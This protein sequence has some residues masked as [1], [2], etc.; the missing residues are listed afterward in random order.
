[1][2]KPKKFGAFAGVFTPS[3]LTI[4]GVIMYMRLGWVVGNAGLITALIIIV[5]SHV[6]SL[7]TGLSISSVATDKKI[8]TGGIYYILSRSLGFPM[9]GAIG[10]ALFIGTALGISLYLVGFAES[11][12]AV[13]E[14]SKFLN[15]NP[16]DTNSLR[17]IASASLL[18][19]VTIAFISTSLAIKSQYFILGAIALSL[20]SI[21]IGFF[22]KTEFA[23][24][25]ISFSPP[26][27]GVSMQVVFGVFFPAVTGFTAGVAM[28]GDLKDPKKG[29]PVG[30]MSAIIVGFVIYILL[31]VSFAV[32]VNSDLLMN[33][34]N[35]LLKIAYFSP[36]VLA[37]IW[38]AT[39]SS[40][41][42]G[43]L[44][45]PRILQ[46]IS[47]DKITP[48]IF[49]KGYGAS[50]EPRN[51]LIFIFL[52]A[53]GGI[54]IGDLNVIAGVVSMFYLAS[55]GFINLAF[56]L[57]NWASTDFRPSFKVKG[58]IGLIGFIASFAVMAQLGMLSMIASLVIMFGLFAWLNRKQLKSE[59]GDVW[60]SVWLSV[61]RKALHSL[62]KKT[63]EYRNWQ[64][65]I[66]LFS[67]G[68]GQRPYLMEFGKN[69]V[70]KYGLLSNFDLHESENKKYLFPKH[71]QA[72][73]DDEIEGKGIFTRRQTCSD[74]Y[75]GIE[76]IISTYGFS[77][78]EPN[79]VLMGWMRQSKNPVR[80][81][82]MISR[83]QELDV[84]ILLVDYDKRYGYGNHKTIDIWWRG[85]GNNGNLALN[86][87]KFLWASE[88]WAGAK[89]RLLVGNPINEKAA[90]IRKHAEQV[91]SNMRIEAEIKIINNQ[92][93]QKSFY[94]LIRTESLKTDLIILGMP[95]VKEGK[96]KE[97]VEQTNKLMLDIG[98]VVL[99]KASSQFKDQN[100]GIKREK[101]NTGIDLLN[102]NKAQK[103]LLLPENPIASEKVA[104]LSKKLTTL[105]NDVFEEQKKLIFERHN[106]L[107]D[108]I[109]EETKVLTDDK[110][111]NLFKNDAS[112][113]EKKLV[114]ATDM[115]LK[116]TQNFVK[117][118]S[119]VKDE[120][121]S[122]ESSYQKLINGTEQVLQNIPETYIYTYSEDDLKYNENDSE[123]IKQFKKK[124]RQQLKRSSKPV[125]YKVKYKK[126][127]DGYLPGN[128]LSLHYSADEKTG[129][130]TIQ[131]I[132]ETQKFIKAVR[133][134]LLKLQTYARENTLSEEL[135]QKEIL[136][137][138]SGIEEIN[139]IKL[140]SESYI[141]N[142][143][144][145][146]TTEIINKISEDLIGFN[147]N[148]KIKSDFS[149]KKIEDLKENLKNSTEF[150][151]RNEELLHNHR[152][153]ELNLID[154]ENKLYRISRKSLAS[155]EEFIT[156][157]VLSKIQNTK[158]YLLSYIKKIEKDPK[159]E[160]VFEKFSEIDSKEEI[161]KNFKQ[162]FDSKLEKL[163]YLAD[164]FPEKV[165]LLSNESFN[166]IIENQFNELET[167]ELFASALI[168]YIIHTEFNT[169]LLA[170]AEELPEDIVSLENSSRNILRIILFSFFD[171]DG[172]II[173]K[174]ENSAK[175]IIAFIKEKIQE[176]D[177]LEKETKLKIQNIN[178]SI[179]ERL[180]EISNKLTVYSLIKQSGTIKRFSSSKSKKTGKLRNKLKAAKIA[181]GKQINQI[182][183]RHSDAII[184][185][186][187]LLNGKSETESNVN[188]SLNF[189]ENVSVKNEVLNK[190]P[191]YYQQLFLRLNNYNKDFFTGR[192]KELQEV[193]K[194]IKRYKSSFN[195]AI[196][197]TG[198]Q[199][200]GKTF[201]TQ[202]AINKF[203]PKSP[204]YTI[205]PPV[206][207]SVSIKTFKTK[208]ALAFDAK[209]SYEHK[210]TKIQTGSV[211]VF[212]EIEL[213]WEKSSEGFD[214]IKEII[215]LIE[216]YGHKF[217]FIL[218]INS[219]AYKLIKQIEN[220][221][222]LFLNIIECKPFNAKQL[223]DAVLFRHNSGSIQF[224][225]KN[226][227]QED[228]R[229]SDYAKLFAKY[230]NLTKG[231]IGSTLFSWTANIEDY[232]N[233]I[234][235]IKTVRFENKDFLND[236]DNDIYLLF[237][238]FML[239][240]RLTVPKLARVMMTDEIAAEKQIS[241]LKRSGIVTEEAKGIFEI[242]KFLYIHIKQKLEELEMI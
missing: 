85:S 129:T 17:I 231:N 27:D 41:L 152:N 201:L 60:Q 107:T 211:I 166:D 207:G 70:G 29:I 20:I 12:L 220:I 82:Q 158:S 104:L 79:T 143:I 114:A 215:N 106:R 54:L 175:K 179:D 183:Y 237:I 39:L 131:I 228:M 223:K 23:P 156:A 9:G 43:I 187:K 36:L 118:Y 195:G 72:Q 38:G 42:G 217:L 74:I 58:V 21:A 5:I 53:E 213:W 172:K 124:K 155:V 225:L 33:D 115:F 222:N 73:F 157:Q 227:M 68:K 52:I 196:L 181:T 170:M 241:F 55:Y 111:K 10:I 48:K 178:R 173:N 198:E 204:V 233:N 37:G 230:F 205:K 97:F 92:I 177:K 91:L 35:F 185:K 221:E 31:A 125:Q 120:V 180:S 8:K 22:T 105:N 236:F 174:E 151:L 64:P 186:K 189:I 139:K 24:D 154:F 103:K 56:F 208:L 40:A 113:F 145:N 197:I 44:G 206:E 232:K 188:K 81:S 136:T 101:E 162:I 83:I 96:E 190:L 234:L 75:S 134:S 71:L 88:D 62:D 25:S 133:N 19:L 149:R 11:L 167:V 32:F 144:Q 229:Q 148:S 28:S 65:N 49:A 90:K 61:V 140:E 235:Q 45:G 132:I 86:L 141:Y 100:I 210:F 161:F 212:D 138:N 57:E 226:R 110:L 171:S 94:E 116:K 89:L 163:K 99:I 160:F 127:V 202:Y 165:R 194:A 146:G 123:E 76:T 169:P 3:V 34:Y 108:S 67:G 203:L 239:H 164:K 78:I 121:E 193:E 242:N 109:I 209:G 182:W 95:E 184:F 98:T 15:L 51:A 150:L 4:L 176:L 142:F 69:L 50:N 47:K 147:S 200:S 2:S 93:E 46:A 102:N 218:N 214:V 80:F 135:V 122:S 117:L 14:V 87:V 6:I 168:N 191:F 66:I 59:S 159:A 18:L 26:K 153:L 13:K 77:G 224:K 199:Y 238:Q 240:K 119:S 30:T 216:E 219:F 128:Y 7:T 16:E 63:L 112:V 137:I 1:M 192:I 130:I 126:I 84:N